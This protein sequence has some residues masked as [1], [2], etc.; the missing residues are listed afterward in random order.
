VGAK[1]VLVLQ[2]FVGVRVGLA[3]ALKLALRKKLSKLALRKKLRICT[4]NLNSLACRLNSNS[5]AF[6][7]SE[8]LRFGVQIPELWNLA[9]R[10]LS[11]FRSALRCVRSSGIPIVS[12]ISAFI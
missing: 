3:T 4:P 7:V 6:I 11:F 10:F 8:I 12:E 9:C 5:L 1:W 2:S